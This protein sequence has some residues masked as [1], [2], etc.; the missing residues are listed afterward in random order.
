MRRWPLWLLLAACGG[1]ADFY[2]PCT[3]A[4]QCADVV[5]EGATAECVDGDAG[6]FCAWTCATDADCAD[7]T[8]D[9]WDFVCAPFESADGNWCF[10]ACGEDD[11]CPDGYSCR[12]TG[13][14]SENEKVCYPS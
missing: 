7:D 6:G 5:P 1:G 11:A 4:D 10:P 9:D 12:S 13:G 3:D 8:D 2:A 14:G